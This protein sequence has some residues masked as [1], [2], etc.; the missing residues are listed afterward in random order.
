MNSRPQRTVK[1]T[2][3]VLENNTN[4][5]KKQKQAVI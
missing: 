5:T 1:P 4:Q 2:L 3:K